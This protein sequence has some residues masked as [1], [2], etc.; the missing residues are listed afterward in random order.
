MLN[1][2]LGELPKAPKEGIFLGPK[3][4]RKVSPVVSHLLPIL[5]GVV[6]ILRKVLSLGV[7]TDSKRSEEVV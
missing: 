2:T 3:R 7:K 6:L 1:K 5:R 4:K